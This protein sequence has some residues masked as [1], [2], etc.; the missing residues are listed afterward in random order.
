MYFS[1]ASTFTSSIQQRRG[2]RFLAHAALSAAA[3][4][5]ML[6][7]AG[8]AQAQSLPKIHV[9]N[10]IEYVS[11]G[12]GSD[13]ATLM[14]D[15]ISRWPASLEFSVK[16]GQRAEYAAK[17]DVSVIDA[18]GQAVLDH[19]TAKG[20]FMLMDLAPGRYRVLATLSGKTLERQIDVKAGGPVRAVFEWPA[21]TDGAG[22]RG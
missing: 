22:Q 3:A 14:R 16:D 5:T 17:V 20:P 8:G 13:E 6:L 10:G 9:S 11:G 18:N 1:S 12:I 4:A 15:S 19:V 21:G 2:M 7:A